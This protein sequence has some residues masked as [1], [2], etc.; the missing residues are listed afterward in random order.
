MKTALVH[1]QMLCLTNHILHRSVPQLG[2][3]LANFL[4]HQKEVIHHMLRLTRKLLPQLLVLCGNSHRTGVQMAFAHHDA[5]Q[6]DEWAGGETVF[7]GTEEAGDRYIAPGL[8]LS[9]GLEFDPIAQSIKNESLLR[10]R[11]AELPGKTGALD[12]RPCR[13]AG[14]SVVT[15]DGDVIGKRLGHAGGDDTDANFR[16]ELHRDFAGG[17]RVL[18]IVD[19]LREILDGV[20]IVVW[21]GGDE[22]H[23]RRRVAGSGNVFRN[24]E[25]RKLSSFPWLGTLSHLD[26]DLVAVRQIVTC[27]A[28]TSRCD[29]LD[30]RSAVIEETLWILPSLASIGPSADGIHGLR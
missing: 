9:V 6:G 7:F 14:A 13:G 24:F 5:S 22:T 17:L 30:C 29:L 16:N 19:E 12:S 2:H 26:L 11:E 27:H 4:C 25:P 10:F 18:Q 28:K 15:T 21:R 23:T 20:N 3:N 1:F 8:E